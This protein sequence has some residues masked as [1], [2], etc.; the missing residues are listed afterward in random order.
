MASSPERPIILE[1]VVRSAHPAL[2]EG[3]DVWLR[4]G[5]LSDEVVRQIC[6]EHLTCP[7]PQPVPV[8]VK[9]EEAFIDPFLESPP[10]ETPGAVRPTSWLTQIMQSFMAEVSVVWLLFLGVFMVVVSSGV[11]AATQWH[12]F[13]SIGQYLILLGYTLAFWVASIFT[14]RRSALQLTSRMLQITTL[15]IIPVNFWMMDGFRLLSSPLGLV[16]AAIAA[17]SLTTL[18]LHLL[19]PASSE[20]GNTWLTAG[21]AIAL[22]WL[23]WGWGWANFPLVATYL[24]MIGAALSLV[25]QEREQ[26][27]VGSGASSRQ[28]TEETRDWGPGAR[29][30]VLG[31]LDTQHSTLI[32]SST[33]PPLHPSTHLPS[34][35][36][37]SGFIAVAFST[38]L[39]IARA[40]L[41]AQ[42]PVPRLG[43]VVG[44]GGWLLCWLSR[45]QVGRAGWARIG[46]GLLI[47][48]WLVAVT[49][50]PP[51]QAIAVSGLGLWLLAD[52]L[53][54]SGQGQYLIAGF[55]MGLQMVWLLWRVLPPNWQQ[56]V[57]NGCIQLAGP[58]AMPFSLAGLW[59]FP[60]LLLTIFLASYLRQQQRPDLAKQTEKLALGLG[61]ALAAVS[62]GNSLVRLINLTLSTLTLLVVV[63]Q[64]RQVER[65]LVYLTH[66]TGLA[67]IAAGTYYL[68]PNLSLHH[69]A[70]MLIV[71]M[72][73]EWAFAGVGDWRQS[74]WHFGLVLAVISYLF[75]SEMTWH[76]DRND[77]GLVW[78]VTPLAL[79]GLAFRRTFS[80]SGLAAWLSV[81]ALVMVQPL[82]F[83]SG[84]ERLIGLGAA[85]VL[86]VLNTQRL[87][88]LI[89]ALLTVGFGLAFAAATVWEVFG[90]N[91]RLEW[92]VNLLAIS[93]LVLWLLRGAL[94]R[95]RTLLA[96][97]YRQAMDGWAIALTLFTLFLLTW[98]NLALYG[99]F[100]SAK[101]PYVSAAALMSVM[102]GLRLWQ[103]I[104]RGGFYLLAWSLEL[105][106]MG[107]V[108]LMG[109]SLD[110]LA[111][112]NLALGLGTQLLGDWWIA[113]A[114]TSNPRILDS[115][116]TSQNP[117][118]NSQ[119]A[120]LS[121][122]QSLLFTPYS[123]H[124][125][126][127]L[128]AAL[129]LFL[130]HRS[131]TASTG[132]YTLAASLVG[133]GIGRRQAAFRPLT[134]LALFGISW[135]AYELLFYQLSQAEGD[136][137][138]D[139]L[140]LMAALAA[141]L[142]IAF[143]LLLP[144]LVPYLRLTPPKI[145]VI[146][147]LHWALGSLL[148]LGAIAPSLSPQGKWWWV[149][150][151]VILAACALAT[152]HHSP[153]LPPA[154]LPPSAPPSSL[155]TY[156][157]IIQSLITLA[158]LLHLLLPNEVLLDWAGAIAALI[159]AILYLTPWHRWGWQRHP[160]RR[161]AIV[162]P[163]IV[164][165][166][167]GGGG[168][169]QS[170]L[171][172]AT[173][174]AW[175][176]KAE[177]RVRLSYAGVLLANWAV[178][179]L[180][181]RYGITEPLWYAALLSASLLY[182]A[183]I[184]P[185][186]RSPS[187]RDKRHLLRCL[188]TA[189]VCLTALYQ[190]EVGIA[191]I[192]PI[193]VSMISSGIA[194]GF[195]MV[196]I[197]LRVRAFLYVGTLAFIIQ[198]LRQLWLFINDYSL[199]LWAMGIALGLVLIWIAA[200]FEARRTQISNLVQYWTSELSEWE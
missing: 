142:A 19:K 65:P 39:L 184:D 5:L 166:L 43:L 78:L 117:E 24:G 71:G 124:V 155:W 99:G 46:A 118:L 196:G 61:L 12:N 127:L 181:D 23:H 141:F 147:H 25:Y 32:H 89:A 90:A 38:L 22:S 10:P 152:A 85:T 58:E 131:F 146:A 162:L 63:S 18:T 197:L 199:L 188:A 86:M 62:A 170:W 17:F 51:W 54:R 193:L 106:L 161:L 163:G 95:R 101:W 1:L 57:I 132:L 175:L 68:F 144:W 176:A 119:A 3:L 21:A 52:Y 97:R 82:T 7:L 157:G 67:A 108:A 66:G 53:W 64:R 11:L 171:V 149:G 173:F 77:W 134:Y 172:G 2:L 164:L 156:A 198:V 75:L 159:A 183:Q 140:V 120:T 103:S 72:L 139:A 56:W 128:Y 194:I 92:A 47:V 153:L 109:R 160:W 100:D 185:G 177:G 195:V 83:G 31:Q 123:L 200:T 182:V 190:S 48:G 59:F 28:E 41:V 122:S 125:I 154:P 192:L 167:F 16:V 50:T 96:E 70:G 145:R 112:L 14:G 129:G 138:G 8:S 114:G 136:H 20:S 135:G 186:L 33:H 81:V 79:T 84:R 98:I 93:I 151:S 44:I 143:R 168:T 9:P 115:A 178:I 121:T 36:L 187:E 30:L 45:K 148:L 73:L 29:D 49:V 6:Q 91:L 42:V 113:K 107:A 179:R 189:L 26:V 69:W 80:P 94:V 130:Q 34:S 105:L 191:G 4:L 76:E 37:T 87:Q 88:H 35:P 126:P 40:I 60:Y 104:Y 111:T 158:Y 102:T 13:S 133:I 169:I 74:A 55:L 110:T 27:G 180:F 137:P 15:L 174:Y 165:L 116:A 150:V